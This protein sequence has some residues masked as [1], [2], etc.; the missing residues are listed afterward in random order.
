MIKNLNAK[1]DSVLIGHGRKRRKR[2]FFWICIGCV[3]GL[4]FLILGP[5]FLLTS[6]DWF[7]V[8]NIEVEGARFVAEDQI[9]SSLKIDGVRDSLFRAYIG[10]GNIFFW[11]FK[12]TPI[13]LNTHPVIRSIKIRTSIIKKSVSVKIEERKIEGIVCNEK[14]DSCFGFD[15]SGFVFIR[16][17]NVD[18]SLI[19]KIEDR[20]AR[21]I[22][23][24][25]SYMRNPEW[26]KNV[27][28]TLSVLKKHRFYP[29]KVVINNQ[30]LEEWRAVFPSGF[31]FY[32]SLR[33]IPE[34]IDAIL[35][36]ILEKVKIDSVSYFDFR[37]P[38][39]IY[40]K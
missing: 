7:S 18:G 8:K 38:N 19:F 32:F 9:I 6:S 31:Q 36:D 5:A 40:Y 34:N 23:L 16:V 11:L 15:S 35:S 14:N 27:T 21:P 17:P 37:V 33:F 13:T 26:M 25:G 3:V 2:N 1:S 4:F 30:D 28:D 12:D 10:S 39:R 22:V 20:S 29:T 24:G